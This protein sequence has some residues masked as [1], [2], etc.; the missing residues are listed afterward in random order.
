MPEPACARVFF[1]LWPDPEVCQALM[2][3][4]LKVHRQ[5]GG[6]LTHAASVHMTLLFLGH[7]PVERL[8]ALTDVAASVPFEAF[9]LRIGKVDCWKHNRIAWVAPSTTPPPLTRL[10][11]SL[12]RRAEAEGF[13]FDPRPFA[14]HVTLVRKAR[15]IPL[16]LASLDIPWG[17]REFLL[18]RSELDSDGSRYRPIGRWPP[19]VSQAG[20][21]V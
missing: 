11:E 10:V 17:V 18:V 3:V 19:P 4:G 6:K 7:T 14:P 21:S 1:A 12:E 8:G 20:S 5:V 13:H 9:A 2:Q 15:C 16:D